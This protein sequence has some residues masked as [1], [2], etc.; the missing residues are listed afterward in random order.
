MK[1]PG[2]THGNI[3]VLGGAF[4]DHQQNV[5]FLQAQVVY[6]PKVLKHPTAK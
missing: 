1:Q 3:H 4:L 6:L 2:S 5:A